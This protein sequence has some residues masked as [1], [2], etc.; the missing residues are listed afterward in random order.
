[1]QTAPGK[2]DQPVSGLPTGTVFHGAGPQAL[3]GEPAR[4]GK[5]PVELT[6][7]PAVALLCSPCFAGGE[8]HKKLQLLHILS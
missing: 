8:K 4:C 1:M 5:R 6:G 3:E 2:P 7:F